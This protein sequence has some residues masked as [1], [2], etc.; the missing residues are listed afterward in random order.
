MVLLRRWAVQVDAP[1][2]GVKNAS[3]HALNPPVAL[4]KIRCGQQVCYVICSAWE[5]LKALRHQPWWSDLNPHATVSA[6]KP[7]ESEGA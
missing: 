5:Q 4:E 6:F 7:A 1:L 2:A 3:F